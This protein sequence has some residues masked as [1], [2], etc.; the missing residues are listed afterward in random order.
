MANLE[1]LLQLSALVLSLVNG[2]ALLYQFARDRPI[3]KAEPIHPDLYQWW[4]HLPPIAAD[5]TPAKRYGFLV[6]VGVSNRG[7]RKV[8]LTSWRLIIKTKRGRQVELI[9]N[10]IPEPKFSFSLADGSIYTKV[11][12]VLGTAGEF[13]KG[14]TDIDPGCSIAGVAYYTA[15]FRPDDHDDIVPSNERIAATLA[16]TGVY[17]RRARTPIVFHK[18][19]LAWVKAAVSG[20]EVIR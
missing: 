4:F 14:S 17:G 13:G 11:L 3:L 15:E 16:I 5:G 8:S 7:L 19:D 12:Q 1:K 10:S 20:I 2:I 9:A 6:Y 18:T